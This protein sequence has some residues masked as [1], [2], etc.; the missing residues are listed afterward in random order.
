MASIRLL[1]GWQRH[2]AV[3]RSPALRSPP[4]SPRW[5]AIVIAG[6][7]WREQQIIISRC[8]FGERTIRRL[9]ILPVNEPQQRAAVT[10]VWRRH[11]GYGFHVTRLHGI[12]ITPYCYMVVRWRRNSIAT[13]IQ[14]AIGEIHVRWLAVYVIIA[15][16]LPQETYGSLLRLALL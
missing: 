1:F 16:W 6:I 10:L 12:D 9:S 3:R 11:G 8:L 15:S 14:H 7:A 4:L 13:L 2:Y 5:F